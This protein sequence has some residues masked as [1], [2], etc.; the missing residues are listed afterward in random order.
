MLVVVQGLVFASLYPLR[1]KM[2]TSTFSS[3]CGRE[4]VRI[5]DCVQNCT[6]SITL[7]LREISG[8]VQ[9]SKSFISLRTLSSGRTCNS[10]L[11]C[12][13]AHC[14]VGKGGWRPRRCPGGV[15]ARG[16]STKHRTMSPQIYPYT[17]SLVKASLSTV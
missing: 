6:L 7:V 17:V 11:L 9:Q 15:P 14:S 12:P 5:C 3:S 2:D 13:S 1:I 8:C 16:A 4:A 10:R